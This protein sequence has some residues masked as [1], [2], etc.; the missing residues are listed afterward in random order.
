MSQASQSDLAT[1]LHQWMKDEMHFHPQGRHVGS[2]LPTVEDLQNICRGKQM[3]DIW[4]FVLERVRSAKT[5]R[6]IKGNLSLMKR[7]TGDNYRVKFEPGQ[8]LSQEWADLHSER[9]KLMAELSAEKGATQHIDRDIE[10]LRSEIVNKEQR[11]EEVR[12]HIHGIQQKSALLSAQSQQVDEDAVKLDEYSTRMK[13]KADALARREEDCTLYSKPGSAGERQAELE[14]A[15][16]RAVRESCDKISTFLSQLLQGAFSSDKSAMYQEKDRLWREIENDF[17]SFSALQ[18]VASL[19]I[20]AQNSSMDLREKTAAINILKDAEKLKFKYDN[21]RLRDTSSPPSIVQSV[22]QLVT[23]RQSV[24]LQRFL[25]TEKWRNKTWR[26]HQHLSSVMEGIEDFLRQSYHGNQGAMN[27]ARSLFETEV[28]IAATR[29]AL[30]VL[31]TTVDHLMAEIDEATREK[32]ALYTKYQKIQDFK[33]LADS[34]QNLIRVLVK[35]NASARGRLDLQQEEI[36]QYVDKSLLDHEATI[37]DLTHQLKDAVT[38]EVDTFAQLSLPFLMYSLLESGLRLAVL[39]LSIHRFN[40]KGH[41]P[42]SGATSVHQSQILHQVLASLEFAPYKAPEGLLLKVVELQKEVDDLQLTLAA[43]E[44]LVR[45]IEGRDEA[46]QITDSSG[47]ANW[48]KF[49]DLCEK[50]TG[51]DK[52]E[53]ETLLPMLQQRL[54]KVT[55]SLTDCLRL[56]DTAKDW[57]EQPAQAT[58]PW[59]KVDSSNLQQW[60][61]KWTLVVTRLRQIEMAQT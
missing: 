46:G 27:L 19:S 48:E 5:T 2:P 33:K 52:E 26:L 10:R 3:Q 30:V 35:Q 42:T 60:R 13:D 28:Q 41:I 40:I 59:M 24:H 58:L 44:L 14:T 38:T 17:T 39:D 18:V 55:Q 6:T 56:K 23:E 51:Q 36:L 4:K 34:K 11:Y 57:W 43:H 7:Q 54:A 32:D 31:D 25:E 16:T 9:K 29:A 21:G 61:D 20:L 49:Q 8:H 53:I 45:N 47:R 15:C 50:V 12:D 22:Q 1:L 37:M